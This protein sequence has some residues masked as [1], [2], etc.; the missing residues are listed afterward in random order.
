MNYFPSKMNWGQ[1]LATCQQYQADIISFRDSGAYS[2][3]YQVTNTNYRRK[4]RVDTSL[5]KTVGWTSAHAVESDNCQKS[6][7]VY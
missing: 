4:K 5:E 7:L 2:L 1:A 3:V 6:F